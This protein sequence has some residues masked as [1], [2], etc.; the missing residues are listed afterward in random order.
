MECSE[1]VYPVKPAGTQAGAGAQVPFLTVHSGEWHWGN[2]SLLNVRWPGL[3]E[4]VKASGSLGWGCLPHF[5]CYKSATQL[6][7]SQL[8]SVLCPQPL[9]GHL[10][11][12]HQGSPSSHRIL[13]VL[14]SLQC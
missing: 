14:V 8:T 9:Q 11:S 5:H 4:S 2:W 13:F 6:I 7:V 1:H 12:H 10:S 3:Q